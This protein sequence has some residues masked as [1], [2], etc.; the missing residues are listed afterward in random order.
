[1]E[2]VLLGTTVKVKPLRLRLRSVFINSS[3]YKQ[4]SLHYW[5]IVITRRPTSVVNPA[6]RC[7]GQPWVSSW[8]RRMRAGETNK[9]VAP[10]RMSRYQVLTQSWK[11]HTFLVTRRLWVLLWTISRL[12]SKFSSNTNVTWTITRTNWEFCVDIRNLFCQYHKQTKA[13]QW[14]SLQHWLK[15]IIE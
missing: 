13:S 2:E 11:N 6:V 5:V 8:H 7:F 12:G 15:R 9:L 1:M 10:A 3:T 4:L 14:S